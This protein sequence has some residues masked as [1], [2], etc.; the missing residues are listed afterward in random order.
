MTYSFNIVEKKVLHTPIDY[1]NASGGGDYEEG[2]YD[3]KIEAS[4]GWYRLFKLHYSSFDGQYCQLTGSYTRTYVVCVVD[5]NDREIFSFEAAQDIVNIDFADRVAGGCVYIT[6]PEFIDLYL[7]IHQTKIN[8]TMEAKIKKPI[9]ERVVII[10][11]QDGRILVKTIDD[12]DAALLS[13]K[14]YVT[15]RYAMDVEYSELHGGYV[16]MHGLFSINLDGE[17]LYIVSEYDHVNKEFTW[18][19]VEKKDFFKN[20]IDYKQQALRKYL[21]SDIGGGV[22]I[23]K[24]TDKPLP[25]LSNLNRFKIAFQQIIEGDAFEGE[26]QDDNYLQ[27]ICDALWHFKRV[28]K[29]AQD[30]QASFKVVFYDYMDYYEFEE[31]YF[32]DVKLVC[33]I[34]KC[35]DDAKNEFDDEPEPLPFIDEILGEAVKT[36]QTGVTVNTENT[37]PCLLSGGLYYCNLN[38]NWF[39]LSTKGVIFVL[40]KEPEKGV[41]I[42]TLKKE[43][44]KTITAG[45]DT[46]LSKEDKYLVSNVLRRLHEFMP[47]N[48]FTRVAHK[49]G[50]NS[51]VERIV[52]DTYNSFLATMRQ[53][54]AVFHER[55]RFSKRDKETK[56]K[57]DYIEYR[58]V[59]LKV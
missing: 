40:D 59:Y 28:I 49:F 55:R 36:E 1:R 2:Y 34:A 54:T 17:C 35:I 26:K 21:V 20:F 5:D 37:I 25:N 29:S 51:Y 22:E 41:K 47:K 9:Y 3:C 44:K 14:E 30:E 18:N 6:I 27:A 46:Y 10:N 24:L 58:I 39:V 42:K 52:I 12:Y 32:S 57:T 4:S 19:V 38:E 56:R 45:N 8:K 16:L 13:V 7:S 15:H 33:Q 11:T 48:W 43:A 53:S 31:Y 23:V 50:F